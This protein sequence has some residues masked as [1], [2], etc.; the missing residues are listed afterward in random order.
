MG[1]LL[2]SPARSDPDSP[3]K[4]IGIRRSMDEFYLWRLEFTKSGYQ[5]RTGTDYAIEI[6]GRAPMAL[7]LAQTFR[8]A[9]QSAVAPFGAGDA[10]IK[11]VFAFAGQGARL[12]AAWPHING[13]RRN[14]I[15]EALV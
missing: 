9:S 15:Q 11:V 12:K 4:R 1:Y 3:M 14:C 13:I 7:S 5:G 10:Q 2:G 6:R 8:Q